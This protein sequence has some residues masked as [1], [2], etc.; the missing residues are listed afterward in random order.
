MTATLSPKQVARAIGVSESSLKR[1][2]DNGVIASERTAGGHRRLS[3]ESVIS[4]LRGAKRTVVKPEVLGLPD[5]SGQTQWTP[6]HAAERLGSALVEG[7]ATACRRIVFD[8]YLDGHDV[9]TI[10]DQVMFAA[11]KTIGERWNQ[12]A[13]EVYVERRSVEICTRIAQELRG[14]MPP[15][16]ADAP[17]AAGGTLDGDPYTLACSMA[18]VVLCHA[19]WNAVPLGNR[20]PF[21]TLQA[22]VVDLQ[23]RLLWLSVSSI[24]NEQVFCSHMD[25]M[26]DLA[27]E[28]GASLV[29]GGAALHNAIRLKLRYSAFCDN[30]QHLI[31]FA[32][33]LN[34][35]IRADG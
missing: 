16:P 15:L 20:L 9:A 19:G 30:Y 33:T 32:Q 2:C 3:K 7:D 31:A 23:P 12:G 13:A 29:L 8:L 6:E 25:R 18:E 5:A 21:H 26:F 11:L 22:A 1:W 34:G 27:V 24:R 35:S 4:F 28:H 14:L 10:F 17:I